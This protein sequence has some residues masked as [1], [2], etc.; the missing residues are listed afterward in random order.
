MTT[1]ENDLIARLQTQL[2][3]PAQHP[4]FGLKPGPDRTELLRSAVERLEQT[5]RNDENLFEV[6]GIY[7]ELLNRGLGADLAKL[8]SLVTLY[9][10]M[11]ADID[12]LPQEVME[13]CFALIPT[14]PQWLKGHEAA[15][16]RGDASID[17]PLSGWPIGNNNEGAK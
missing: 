2:A 5:D 3:K 8:L 13:A 9:V 10:E 6:R 4:L 17:A 11:E 16:E 15:V 12:G 14:K 1:T 7:A